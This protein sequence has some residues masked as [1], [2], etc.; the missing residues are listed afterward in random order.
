MAPEL[1]QPGL[2]G[3]QLQ[4]ELRQPLAKVG[5]EPLQG[6]GKVV[7]LGVSAW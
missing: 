3:M 2:V 6:L 5:K 1:D 7:S 4:P